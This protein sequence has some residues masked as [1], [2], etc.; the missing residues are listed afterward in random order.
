MTMIDIK[1]LRALCD[2]CDEW[3]AA[4]RLTTPLE[5]E[6]DFYNSAHAALPELLD[7][8]EALRANQAPKLEDEYAGVTR[9]SGICVQCKTRKRP[10]WLSGVCFKCDPP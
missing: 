2:A 9:D 1:H 4:E 6:A 5:A 10:R 8:L 7:E 3:T